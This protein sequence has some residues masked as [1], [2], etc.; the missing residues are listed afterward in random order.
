MRRLLSD[1]LRRGEQCARFG[2]HL[3]GRLFGRFRVATLLTALATLLAA[4]LT[5]GLALFAGDAALF[6]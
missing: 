6:A 3:T 4:F 5:L 1:G 2:Q